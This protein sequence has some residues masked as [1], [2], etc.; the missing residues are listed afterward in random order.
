MLAKT[1][2]QFKGHQN[3]GM[4]DKIKLY[5]NA[6]Q[7]SYHPHFVKRGQTTVHLYKTGVV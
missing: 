5:I 6:G 2:S 7:N 3:R 1:E 4:P